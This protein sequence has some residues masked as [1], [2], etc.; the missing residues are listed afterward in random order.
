MSIFKNIAIIS[1]INDDSV[2]DSLNSV[3][4]HLDSK[5]I[6]YFLDKNSSILLKNTVFLILHQM[7]FI[8]IMIATNI[9]PF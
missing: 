7:Q 5:N 3:V 2:K 9:Y 8:K 6:K 1:K 4:K